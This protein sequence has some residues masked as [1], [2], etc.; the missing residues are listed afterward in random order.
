[1]FVVYDFESGQVYRK[2]PKSGDSIFKDTIT[3]GQLLVL[4]MYLCP[5]FNYS[6]ICCHFSQLLHL[7]WE[8]NSGVS[9]Q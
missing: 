2:Y 3:G 9:S 8:A 4:T 1:M 5:K 7:S 6:V